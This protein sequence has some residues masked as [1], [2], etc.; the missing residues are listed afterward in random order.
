MENISIPNVVMRNVVGGPI[1]LELTSRSRGPNNPP[2]GKMRNININNI[3]C[4]DSF[5][6]SSING[7]KGYPIE[8]V[9]ISNVR[10]ISHGNGSSQ[11]AEKEP[12]DILKSPW[13]GNQWHL[14]SYGF[15]CR[16]VKGLT[17]QNIRL[18]TQHKD[19]RPAFVFI[20][21]EQLEL[22]SI[23]A[24]RSDDSHPPIVFKD[25]TEL[26]I[27][28]CYSLPLITP[29]YSKFRLSTNTLLSGKEFSALLTASS[30]KGGVAAIHLQ[31]DSGPLA[32]R[33]VWLD[34]NRPLEIEF[35]GL[36][37]TKPGMHT[38]IIENHP[39]TAS[40]QVKP[41]SP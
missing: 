2:P 21:V 38:L 40:L 16:H 6:G 5:F 22:Y 41:P 35:R 33:Y 4:H 8:N 37:L 25:V 14:P 34:E 3:I 17:F 23:K 36:T 24:Q 1:N 29:T 32:T 11:D 19:P 10:A 15:F 30:G 7:A 20:D 27:D 39:K 28:N 13:Q 26:N 18:N 9:T 31:A 12:D